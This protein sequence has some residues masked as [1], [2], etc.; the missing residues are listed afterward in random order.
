MQYYLFFYFYI[1]TEFAGTTAA[2]AALR[3]AHNR[4]MHSSDLL[5]FLAVV[6]NFFAA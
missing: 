2:T 5:F 1:V 4:I 6:S 3:V